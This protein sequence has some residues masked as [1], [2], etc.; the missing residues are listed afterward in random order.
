M[1]SL[2]VIVVCFLFQCVSSLVLYVKGALCLCM[3]VC[4]HC[5]KILE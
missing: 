2:I 3:F 4:L 1:I 5:Q